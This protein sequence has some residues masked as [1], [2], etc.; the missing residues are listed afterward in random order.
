MP[1]FRRE[2]AS[3]K[4]YFLACVLLGIAMSSSG[5]RNE[6]GPRSSQR[7]LDEHY[8]LMASE[9][10]LEE[11]SGGSDD[12]TTDDGGDEMA[13]D[14]AHDGGDDRADGHETTDSGAAGGGSETTTKANRQRKKRRPNKVGTTRESFTV[15]P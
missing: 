6:D 9:V 12:E 1:N 4:S 15:T 13:D 10:H 11:I 2:F 5:N 7:D 3:L 14:D 8:R